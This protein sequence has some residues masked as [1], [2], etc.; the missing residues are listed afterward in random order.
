MT[1]NYEIGRPAQSP[2]RVQFKSMFQEPKP[3]FKLKPGHSVV[4]WKCK[5]QH[6]GCLARTW[7]LWGQVPESEA[8]EAVRDFNLHSSFFRYRIR[9][10]RLKINV[11]S[12]PKI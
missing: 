4:E 5:D 1:T 8:A 6:P 10:D 11:D 9:P 7:Q 3:A 2:S 12:P